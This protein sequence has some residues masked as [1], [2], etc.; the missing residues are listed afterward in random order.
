[1]VADGINSWDEAK[2]AGTDYI[3]ASDELL[4]ANFAAIMEMLG[5]TAMKNLVITAPGST[6]DNSIDVSYDLLGMEMNSGTPPYNFVDRSASFTIDMDTGAAMNGYETGM[7]TAAGWK[8]IYA[9]RDDTNGDTK[10][11]LAASASL[12]SVTEPDVNYRFGR[13]IGAA[14]WDGA[15]TFGSFTQE[16]DRVTFKPVVVI[17]SGGR[18]DATWASVS[19]SNVVPSLARHMAGWY[20]LENTTGTVGVRQLQLRI[21]ANTSGNYQGV[22]GELYIE[23]SGGLNLGKILVRGAFEQELTSQAFAY[24]TLDSGPN[25]DVDISLGSYWIKI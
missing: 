5:A 3:D 17:L 20:K 25:I 8:Y 10:G 21:A 6:G 12:G 4:R 1:M 9:Y 7:S 22:A 13:L 18:S 16:N 24:Y 15:S 19:L 14:Y 23:G 2:P 11:L